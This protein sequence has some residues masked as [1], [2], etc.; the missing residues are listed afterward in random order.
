MTE[1]RNFTVHIKGLD[2]LQSAVKRYPK[3]AEPILIK[4]LNATNAVFAKNTLKNDPVPWRTG[5]LT[6]T[7]VFTPAK[8]GRLE[9]SW[10][11]TR[12]YAPAVEFG[13]KNQRAK[14]YMGKIL[15]KAQPEI[16]EVM[17]SALDKITTAIAK[18]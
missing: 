6:Q 10:R 8:S 9:A 16:G 3:I 18:A 2:K 1:P 13:T 17:K 11:P 15:E 4:T 14:P 7:F 5:M 12:I